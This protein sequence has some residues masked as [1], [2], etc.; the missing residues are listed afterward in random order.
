MPGIQEYLPLA[1]LVAN[2]LALP[3]TLDDQAQADNA[4]RQMAQ[5]MPGINP[6]QLD[7]L[8]PQGHSFAG[9]DVPVLGSA[10]RGVGTV[11]QVLQGVLGA[12]P[13]AP[14]PSLGTYLQL[15]AVGQGQAKANANKK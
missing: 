13:A 10:L 11:G 8:A 2:V 6:Q 4:F 7:A 12:P 3:K 9:A 1:Q 14:R 15:Q 5:G